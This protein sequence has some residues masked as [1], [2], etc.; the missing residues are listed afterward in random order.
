MRDLSS[1]ETHLIGGGFDCL[2]IAGVSGAGTGASVGVA[3]TA[4]AIF[5]LA[6]PVGIATAAAIGIGAGVIGGTVTGSMTSI[7]VQRGFCDNR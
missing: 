2:I 6:S 5:G 4:A 1:G 7:L 3:L